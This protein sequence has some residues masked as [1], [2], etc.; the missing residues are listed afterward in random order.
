MKSNSFRSSYGQ[1][2]E[3]STY[4]VETVFGILVC[5]MGLLF[6]SLL[7]GNVQVFFFSG[8][9]K[10]NITRECYMDFQ[11]SHIIVFNF[12]FFFC[13]DMYNRH[14][15]NLQQQGWKNGGLNEETPRNGWRIGNYHRT[16][17]IGFGDL[18][19][20][21][22]YLQEVLKKKRFFKLY[23]LTYGEKFRSIFVLI[24]FVA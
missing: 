24:L 13:L 20:T 19:S 4:A 17:R 7:I 23:H 8:H 5:I 11:V 9:C 22:G 2:L 21:T 18:S 12:F 14:I 6:F 1:S 16:C 15:C 10:M 3:A